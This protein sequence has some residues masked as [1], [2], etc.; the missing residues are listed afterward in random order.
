MASSLIRSQR[1]VLLFLLLLV[2][3]FAQRN[4][5]YAHKGTRHLRES[6]LMVPRGGEIF[7]D[8]KDALVNIGIKPWVQKHTLLIGKVRSDARVGC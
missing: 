3:C 1:F 7:E 6:V 8:V 2:C 5:A 4:G